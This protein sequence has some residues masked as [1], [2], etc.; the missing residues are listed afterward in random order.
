MGR[1]FGG[2]A[3]V[4]QDNELWWLCR[5][6]GH[7]QQCTHAELFHGSAVEHFNLESLLTG[8]GLGGV[9]Q[10]GWRADIGWQVGQIFGQLKTVG[11]GLGIFNDFG[12]LG[13]THVTG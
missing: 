1:I 2:A 7:G 4:L 11:Q 5:T 3:L 8:Q 6:L 13:R 12:S 10:I 9:G